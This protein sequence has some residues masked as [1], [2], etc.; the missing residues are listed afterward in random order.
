MI[1]NNLSELMTPKFAP[2]SSSQQPTSI[3]RS[4]WPH[5]VKSKT[6]LMAPLPNPPITPA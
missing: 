1:L 2:A 5:K 4:H 3:L 6:E